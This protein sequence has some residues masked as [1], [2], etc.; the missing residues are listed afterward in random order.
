MARTIAQIQNQ[1]TT[2]WVAA[3]AAVGITIDPVH[4]SRRNLQQLMLN[5]MASGTAIFEQLYDSYTASVEAAIAVASPQ[6]GAWFQAQMLAFQFNVAVPQLLQFNTATFAPYYP[7][8]VSAYQVIKFCSVVPGTFGTT[9]IKVATADTNGLPADLETGGATA[10]PGALAAAQSYV[11]LLAVG[12]ITCS[13]SSGSSDKLYIA[14][15]VYYQGGYSAVIQAAVISAVQAALTGI[16]FNGVVLLSNIEA[17]I[18]AVAGVNDV[19][20][21]N[22]Q[23]RAA[24]TPYGSGTSLVTGIDGASPSGNTIQRSW[25]TVAGYIQAETATGHLLTNSLTLIAQ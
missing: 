10:Y 7:S 8:V 15:T 18:K 21:T 24:G 2:A 17:A 22:V 5:V 6:T 9:I 19:V 1:L 13:V 20:L 4:W 23:A 25:A 11:N 12:G 16:P 14:A 3:M